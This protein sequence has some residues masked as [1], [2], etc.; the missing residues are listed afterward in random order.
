ME[1]A[2]EKLSWALMAA[3][4]QVVLDMFFFAAA[5]VSENM[6]AL[7][8]V[9]VFVLSIALLTVAQQ[10]LVDQIRRMNPEKQGSVYDVHFN[11]KWLASCD[12][13]EQKQIGQAA[14]KAYHTV[15]VACPFLWMTMVL[16]NYA[17]DFGLLMPAFTVC[18]LWLL[19]NVTYSLE[20]IR[21]SRRKTQ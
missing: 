19:L 3:A 4:V 1:Q 9:A 17:F 21:L 8:G 20:A 15:N 14:Y 5:V 11:K 18:L 10:K 2:E 7:I 13:A 6:S 16:L 12:E